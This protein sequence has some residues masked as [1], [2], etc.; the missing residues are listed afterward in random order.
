[1]SSNSYW[2]EFEDGSLEKRGV[3][4]HV[5][6]FVSRVI[7]GYHKSD[8]WDLNK[9][10]IAFVPDRVEAYTT[11]QCEHGKHLPE[12]F[13]S[14]PAAWAEVLRKIERA[15]VLLRDWHIEGN[16]D[17]IKEVEEGMALFGRYFNE[18]HG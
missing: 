1:M 5:R 13:M 2:R 17:Q 10:L 4:F 11:W 3:V 16:E 18:L 9:T 14:D 12:E 8:I 15:W 7:H 6:R